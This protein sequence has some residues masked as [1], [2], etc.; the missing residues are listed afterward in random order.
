MSPLAAYR[1][2]LTHCSTTGSKGPPSRYLLRLAGGLCNPYSTHSPVKQSAPH[3]ADGLAAHGAVVDVGVLRAAV[4]APDGHVAHVRH[5]RARALRDLRA[6][7][8][9]R[10]LRGP[11]HRTTTSSTFLLRYR[12]RLRR[13]PRP[14]RPAQL[15][16]GPYPYKATA[17]ARSCCLGESY[18]PTACGSTFGGLHPAAPHPA[19][20]SGTVAQ[21]VR[22]H[23]AFP[24]A[25][26]ALRPVWPT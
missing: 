11:R 2:T 20:G 24:A 8:Q 12:Y 23:N 19:H 26:P 6:C 22:A 13:K 21:P 17:P 25:P 4:V 3:L 16:Q 15:P 5:V 14:A 9:V 10:A 7:G 1:Y 18:S